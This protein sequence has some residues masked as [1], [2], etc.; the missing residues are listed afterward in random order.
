MTGAFGETVSFP[1]I[2]SGSVGLSSS[3]GVITGTGLSSDARIANGI[4]IQSVINYAI[5][6]NKYVEADPGEYEFD[7]AGG[8]VVD[9]SGFVWRGS[10][11]VRLKQFAANTPVITLGK[12]VS[13]GDGP[14][15][16]DIQGLAALYGAPQTGNTG[17]NAIVMASSW[18]SRFAQL[19]A[20]STS[21]AYAPYRSI[22]FKGSGS[23]KWWFSNEMSDCGFGHAQNE[24]WRH[25]LMSTG[26]V[27]NNIYIGGGNP[28]I[29]SYASQP[30]IFTNSGGRGQG[31]VFNQFNIEWSS[32]N[33]IMFLDNCRQFVFNS[34]HIEGCQLTGSY[35]SVF[36]LNS[37]EVS[38]CGW[39]LENC[40]ILSPAASGAPAVFGG[41]GASKVDVSGM[42]LGW[43]TVAQADTNVNTPYRMMHFGGERDG[44]G[45]RVRLRNFYI[46]GG[47]SY[48]YHSFIN[49]GDAPFPTTG[50]YV[51]DGNEQYFEDGSYQTIDTD[52][53]V[54]GCNRNLTVKYA[55]SLAANRT[56]VL[57]DKRGSAG[58]Q[59]SAKVSPGAMMH[60]YRQAGTAANTVTVKNLTSGGTTLA[61]NSTADSHMRFQFDGTNWA[62]VQ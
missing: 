16:M 40:K 58:W 14:Y 17:A 22:Y 54:Y 29:T 28:T 18:R 25:S 33:S 47:G 46:E 61:T 34:L 62:Q 39:D 24:I 11:N 23:D 10:R 15:A 53:T 57:S 49:T 8:L 36:Y 4:A 9:A 20:G 38:G 51:Y 55:A 7:L 37:S 35:P 43:L 42:R 27:Y 12:D 5:S 31:S 32:G 41:W 13:N 2:I 1:T 19:S 45:S 50:T 6:S 21:G 26:N 48:G 56:L 59:A 52:F 44:F 30:V 3:F 60:L